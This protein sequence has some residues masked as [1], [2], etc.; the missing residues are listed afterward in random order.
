MRKWNGW[1]DESSSFPVA[2]GLRAYLAKAIGP[3]DALPDATLEAVLATVGASRLPPHPLIDTDREARVRHA[4]GH[5]LP[6]WL[7]MRS[8]RFEAFPEGGAT[9]PP[10]RRASNAR[11]P[12]RRPVS[13]SKTSAELL[14]LRRNH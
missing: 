10:I 11:R 5:S 13:H 1:G 9:A 4:C 6:D 12:P 8:G 7:A 2:A 3:G 14:S